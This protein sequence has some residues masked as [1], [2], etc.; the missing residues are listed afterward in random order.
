MGCFADIDVRSKLVKL[1]ME[2]R[3][4]RFLVDVVTIIVIGLLCLRRD[5]S[6]EKT[7]GSTFSATA[8]S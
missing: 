5:E 4:R 1:K 8:L 7:T 6:G 3:S 2:A